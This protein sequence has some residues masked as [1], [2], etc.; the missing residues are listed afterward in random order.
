MQFRMGRMLFIASIHCCAHSCAGQL[1]WKTLR[2]L[3][4]SEFLSLNQTI[5]KAML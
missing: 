5:G 4:G 3:Q 1:D 2:C